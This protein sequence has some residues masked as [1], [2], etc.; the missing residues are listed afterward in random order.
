MY[1]RLEAR[2]SH[3]SEWLGIYACLDGPELTLAGRGLHTPKCLSH[4]GYRNTR[5][6]FT[7]YGWSRYAAKLF[8]AMLMHKE[9][10]HL[11]YRVL[12]AS[13]KDL[14]G[15]AISRGSV[16]IV[17]NLDMPQEPTPAVQG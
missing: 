15:T 11:E 17:E 1:Y 8:K 3:T 14:K 10:T 2:E 4:G 7:E 6:W 5:S 16:Q 13:E 12:T 9:W